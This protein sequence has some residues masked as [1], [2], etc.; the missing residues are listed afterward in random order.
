MNGSD[1]LVVMMNGVCAAVI[2]HGGNGLE[3]RYDDDYM[4]SDA[5]PLSL[6][7][8]FSHRPYVRGE[9]DRWITSLLPDDSRVLARWYGRQQVQEHT[10]FGLLSTSAGH[11]CAGAV[12][13]CRSGYEDELSE[14]ASGLR[15]LSD[16]EVRGEI[17]QITSNPDVWTPDDVEPYFSLGG[18]QS[19]VAWHRTEDGW[20]RPFGNTPTT[21]ILKP[22][23]EAAETVAI[24]EHLCLGAARRLGIHAAESWIAS[25]GTDVAA[26]IVRYDRSL[27][28]DQW[29]RVHQEDMCQAMGLPGARKYEKDGG[30]G[31]SQ[32]A[33][34][35][36]D[37]SAA[38]DDDI[39]RFAD[40]LLYAWLVV[41]RDAHARNYSLIHM[42]HGETRLAPLYD[43]NS[44]LMFDHTKIG[45]REMAMRY[46]NGFTVYQAGSQDMLRSM[47]AR[48]RVSAAELVTRAEDLA[49][50]LPAAI[51]EEI[52]RL[53]DDLQRPEPTQAFLDRIERRSAACKKTI[54]AT[55][56]IIG[57]SPGT[58]RASQPLATPPALSACPKRVK[59]TNLPCL[60][61]SG[62][63]GWCRSR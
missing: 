39:K 38:P 31:M 20:A 5:P 23:A 34:L 27:V 56:K 17:A 48:L 45:E 51:R 4:H 8:G 29:Q 6:S 55:R 43:V 32:I 62:H 15:L 54:M 30:P 3:L 21:H 42:I 35:I 37:H 46:D 47:A 40:G 41:N 58:G 25:Y 1:A 33:D 13:F 9:P 52:N 18:F 14:R 53:P 57:R 26:V 60:L 11:D 50:R 59:S 19:K 2:H 61:P 7:L 63:K 36:W 10:P 44:S 49:E 22:R 16:A 12:Q 24:G 28:G